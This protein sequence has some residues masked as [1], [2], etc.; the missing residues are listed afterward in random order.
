[1]LSDQ[2]TDALR[3]IVEAALLA[4]DNALTLKDLRELFIDDAQPADSQLL[5][6]IDTL[7]SDYDGRGIELVE[8]AGG[9]RIRTREAYAPWVGRL[10]QS[11]P[12]RLS[13]ALLET[14]AIIAYRQPVTRGEME[15]IRGVAVSTDI[16]ARL[17]DHDWIREVGR[18]DVPG[19]PVLYGTTA[20]FLEFFQLSGLGD[21]PPL[22]DARD[23]AEIAREMNI[24]MPQALMPAVDINAGEPTGNDDERPQS[25]TT[26]QTADRQTT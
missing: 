12:K 21:L 18:R 4:A 10:F 25:E 26:D 7:V 23:L 16:I 14:L 2:G 20:T 13:R 8:I 15:E 24:E 11:R 6:A 17:S 3:N 5:Q 1:M 19:R 22:N 9:Y